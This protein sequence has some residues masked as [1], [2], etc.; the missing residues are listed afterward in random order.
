M[1]L[2]RTV[3]DAALSMGFEHLVVGSLAPLD[4][5]RARYIDWLERGYSAGMNYLKRDPHF[6]TSPQYLY[7][8]SRCVLIVSVSYYSHVPPPPGYFFGRVARYAAGQDYHAVLRRKMRELQ[9]LIESKTGRTLSGKA[10]TDDVQLYEPGLAKRHGLG[11]QGRN[12]MIIGPRLMGS[13]NF[14]GELF[15]DL[16]IEPDFEY[17][18]TCGQCSRCIDG[19]PTDAIT[20][21]NQVDGN[22]CISYLTIENK[23]GIPHHLRAALGNWVFGCDVCQDV[24]PYNQRPRETPWEEF[25]PES[26]AGHYLDLLSLLQVQ[27]D[28]EFMRRFGQTPLRRPKRRGLLRNALTVLGNLLRSGPEQSVNVDDEQSALE[29]IFAFADADDD[30]MLLEHAAWA[31]AQAGH[32][33]GLELLARLERNAEHTNHRRIFGEYAE[34][35]NALH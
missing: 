26:G 29:K 24:C 23:D 31:L 16:E 7:P 10:Y 19:C 21:N 11:F 14:V 34:R 4:S 1:D 22:R 8:G 2:K 18:G 20:E 17:S 27:S 33:R 9:A 13:F 15:T 35:L 5:E 32:S 28:D 30:P 6:R 25:R 12:T 3:I